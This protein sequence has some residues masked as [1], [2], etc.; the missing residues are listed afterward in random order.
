MPKYRFNINFKILYFSILCIFILSINLQN[1]QAQFFDGG[2]NPPGLH[3]RQI[4]TQHFQ[5]LYPTLLEGEA[6]RMANSLDFMIQRISRSL[7]KE[8]RAIT[9]ILQNQ[10]IESNGFVQLA[11]RRSEFYTLPGQEFDYQD[12]LNSLAVHELRHVVQMDKLTGNVRAPFESLAFAIFGISLPAWFFEGDAVLTETLLTNAGRGRQPSWEMPFRANVLSGRDFSYSKNYLGSLTDRTSGY[13]PLGFFMVSKMRR[14]YGDLILDTLISQVAKHPLRLF[15]LSSTSKKLTG[16]TTEE[17]YK[18]T[19]EELR[20]R[21][22]QQMEKTKTHSYAALN[23]RKKKY[24]EDYLLPQKSEKGSIIALKHSKAHTARLVELRADGTEHFLLAIGIQ[25]ESNVHVS[26]TK[27][28]WDELR[29]DI[30]Y[31]KRSY[32]VICEYDL[33]SKKYRQLTHKTRLFAPALSPDGTKIIAVEVDFSNKMAFVE[34]DAQTGA[35]LNR[36]QNNTFRILQSPKYHHSGSKIVYLNVSQAGKS[37]EE[38]NLITGKTSTRLGAQSAL[39]ASPTYAFNEILF[40]GHYN[41]IDNIYHLDTLGNV[42]Q[43][44]YAKFGAFFPSFDEKNSELLFNNFSPLGYDIAKISIKEVNET[45]LSATENHFIDY[46]KP[47]QSAE[48]PPIDFNLIPKQ[49]FASKKYSPWKNAL[50]LHSLVPSFQSNA[51]TD[52]LNMGLKLVSNNLLNTFDFYTG[53]Q[54]NQGLDKGEFL[55]GFTYKGL[56]PILTFDYQNRARKTTY[57]QADITWRE[58]ES[59]FSVKLPFNFNQ[60]NKHG[61]AD[62]ELATSY[63]SRHRIQGLPAGTSLPTHIDFPVRYSVS[64]GQNNRQGNRDLGPKWGQNILV[65]YQHLPFDS[66]INGTIISLQSLF[67]S[68]GLW[69]N[70]SFSVEANYQKMQGDAFIGVIDIPTVSGYTLFSNHERLENTILLDYRFPLAYPDWNILNLSYIKQL[71]AG[72]FADFENVRAQKTV[73]PRSYG[74]ELKADMNVFRFYSPT[75]TMGGKIIFHQ[76]VPAKNPIFEFG[77]TYSY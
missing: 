4:R 68:P 39:L 48:G 66:Q 73:K 50:N 38:L 53:Y 22:T 13:Y 37:I 17:W 54:Y 61:Y 55:A 29:E 49:R 14:D 62:F 44:S 33:E 25:Q 24:T 7:N 57:N 35:E 59:T 75:V 60:L 69:Q 19:T 52:D 76:E 16:L 30:R 72:F 65:N 67:F 23:A 12:W 45:P 43:V 3:W 26:G 46:A 74:L 40:K 31:E 32:S 63:T 11:P 28:V 47:L 27:L 20:L 15:N 51:Y 21:W 9:V 5:I 41:G 10:T 8:P 2:Q 42:S 6:Q 1:A 64:L 58:Q 34:L 70:H 71:R 56:Y 77:L 36:Y 18:A